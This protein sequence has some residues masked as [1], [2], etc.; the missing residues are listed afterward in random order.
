MQMDGTLL[1][2]PR[3]ERARFRYGKNDKRIHLPQDT[4]NDRQA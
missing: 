2:T 3:D 4:S 1:V